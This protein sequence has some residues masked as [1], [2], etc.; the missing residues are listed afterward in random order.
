MSASRRRRGTEIARSPRSYAPSTEALNSMPERASTSCNDRPFWRRIERNRSPTTG[1]LMVTP[2][3]SRPSRSIR[4]EIPCPRVSLCVTNITLRG[5]HRRHRFAQSENTPSWVLPYGAPRDQHCG[6][7]DRGRLRPQD[8]ESEPQPGRPL[9]ILGLA[10]RRQRRR[11]VGIESALGPHDE[12]P[13][14]AGWSGQ[15][16]ELLAGGIGDDEP[17]AAA[18]LRHRQHAIDLGQPSPSALG[19]RLPRD[20]AQAGDGCVGAAPTPTADG[21]TRR[22][23]RDAV[24]AELGELLHGEVGLRSLRE[25]ERDD[26]ARLERRLDHRRALRVEID[27]AGSNA[28]D[29]IG[30][31]T[32]VAVSGGEC[33]A[34]ADAP[35][36]AEVMPGLVVESDVVV[37]RGQERVCGRRVQGRESRHYWK[38]ERTRS[39]NPRSG[40]ATSSPRSSASWRSSSSSS[41]RNLAG[42]STSRRTSRSPR[43]RPCSDG[44][45]LPLSRSTWP[46]CAPGGTRISSSSPSSVSI[47]NTAPSAA[48]VNETLRTCTRSLPS[49]SNSGC[50]ATA[51]VTYRSPAMPPRGAAG[52]RSGSRSRCPLSTPAGTSTSMRRSA[53]TRPSPRQSR[54]GE[55]MRLPVASQAG[56][57]DAVTIWPRIERRTWRT[58]PVPP[59]VSQRDG[60]VP[61]SHPDPSQRSQVTGS[62]TS[63]GWTTPNAASRRVSSTATSA[64]KPRGGPAGP[65]RP[66]KASP[67]KK[68]SNRSPSPKASPACPAP[69]RA[70]GAPSAPK[71][72]YR[73]RRSGSLSVS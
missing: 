53:C 1:P 25:R 70:L 60:C 7:G 9:V 17:G 35:H 15:A 43:R 65:R 45:P 49:R 54:H 22:Q 67:L 18:Q 26:Q 61:G 72:S 11:L 52:P 66:P 34:G 64:S 51:I 68:A 36:S 4:T 19:R 2:C 14:A 46:G 47:V 39:K 38:A 5:R 71:T 16:L 42:T 27:R 24:D 29:G 21:T 37:E 57:G 3:P 33:F 20:P 30:A 59:H 73:R 8:M 32:P 62:R 41:G 58:S 6:A 50:G 10:R 69:G 44:T 63:T 56:H 28:H 13:L 12:H 55:R 40:G 23:Q 31:P 48:C